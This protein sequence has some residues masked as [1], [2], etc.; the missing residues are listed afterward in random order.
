[1]K[2]MSAKYI[3]SIEVSFLQRNLKKILLITALSGFILPQAAEAVSMYALTDLSTFGGTSSQAFDIN[4]K[5]QIVGWA[6]DSSSQRRAYVWQNGILTQLNTLTGGSSQAQGINNLGQITGFENLAGGNR[7]ALLWNSPA[8]PANIGNLGGTFAAGYG[9]NDSGQVAGVSR[10][11]TGFFLFATLWDGTPVN[12]N[13]T[14][15]SGSFA[16]DINNGGQSVGSST[17]NGDLL[18]TVWEADG[19]ATILPYFSNGNF[20]QAQGINDKGQVVGYSGIDPSN[21]LRRATLWE[22][23]TVTNLGVLAGDETSTALRINDRAQVVGW[24]RGGDSIVS[25]FLW[26]EGNMFDLNSLTKNNQGW[27]LEFAWGVN[28]RGQIV[29]YGRNPDNQVRAFL[30]T[31]IPEPQ[32]ILGLFGLGGWI[33]A[34]GRRR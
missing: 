12:L 5:G 16:W 30:L 29:G 26:E 8:T 33:L 19:S 18:A 15:S 22:N 17:V 34:S 31:P 11:A 1:M 4:D 7:S 20:A 32:T 9:V 25:A 13:Q 21:S 14:D 10:G 2:L 6:S 27:Q 23:G 3:K 28:N 24:S